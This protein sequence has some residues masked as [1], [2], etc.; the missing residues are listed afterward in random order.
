MMFAAR[1]ISDVT[2]LVGHLKYWRRRLRRAEA[3][4]RKAEAAGKTGTAAA[5]KGQRVIAMR[6]L[7]ELAAREGFLKSAEGEREMNRRQIMLADEEVKI[8]KL[9]EGQVFVALKRFST[10]GHTYNRDCVVDIARIPEA[11]R[12]I[13]TG[14]VGPKFARDAGTV[15]PVAMPESKPE[16]GPI[17]VVI[18]RG[19]N[20]PEAFRA[21][22]RASMEASPGRNYAEV[23][24]AVI[25]HKEG[26]QLYMLAVRVQSEIDARASGQYGRRVVPANL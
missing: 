22:I 19:D 12:L 24:S 17:K 6:E 9:I 11:E 5:F 20:K 26:G 1:H 2:L 3:G 7:S 21:T 25:D 8:A 16:P 15:Q 23:R 18:V 10:R 4:I 13:R 14:F